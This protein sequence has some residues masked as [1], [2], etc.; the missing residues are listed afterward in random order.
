MWLESL[1]QGGLRGLG[2]YRL[3]YSTAYAMIHATSA[4]RCSALVGPL[5]NLWRVLQAPPRRLT[6]M[7]SRGRRD[8]ETQAYEGEDDVP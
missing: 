2:G 5:E 8:V 7:S 4:S 6:Q 1:A 3:F